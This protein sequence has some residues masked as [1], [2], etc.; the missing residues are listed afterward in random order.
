MAT[1]EIRGHAIQGIWRAML[2]TLAR[3]AHHQGVKH[4]LFNRVCQ[5]NMTP[6]KCAVPS[7]VLPNKACQG[8]VEGKGWCIFVLSL[9]P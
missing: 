3:G 8:V 6:K 5:G 1:R 7:N 9:F 4:N 2:G